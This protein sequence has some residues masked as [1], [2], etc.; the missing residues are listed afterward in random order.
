MWRALQRRGSLFL[1]ALSE[2]V[3]A[4]AGR[5]RPYGVLSIGLRGDLAEEGGE[6]RI[7]GFVRR[8]TTDYLSLISLLRWA[9]EDAR[10]AAVF[11]S[12]DDVRASW[13]R[14]QGLRR[15]VQRLREA[16]KHVWVHLNTAGVHEYYLASAA[17][18]ISL[19]PTA[20]LNVTGLSS[21]AVFFLDALRK[22][23]VEAEVIQMGRYKAAG[24]SFT[25]RDMSPAHRE[26][27]ESLIDDLYS[28]LVDGIGAGRGLEPGAVRE[29][30]DRGPFVAREALEAGLIDRLAYE[31]EVESHLVEACSSAPLIDRPAYAKRRGRE[32]RREVLRRGRGT[33]G[34]L[35][36]CGTIKMGESIPGP[37]GTAAVGSASV[38]AALKQLRER[39]DVRALVVRVASPGGSV[40][41]SDLM[42]REIVRTREKKPVV[43]SFGDV[44]ASGGYYVALGG[45]PVLAEP[46]SITGSI[47]V[48]AGKA[49]L[50]GLYDRIG[51]TKELVSRGRHAA[52]YSD[53]APL[54]SEERARIRAEAEAFYEGFIG[55]VAE[56][57]RLSPGAVAAA[58]E[59]RVWSGRQAWT[60]GLVDEMGGLEEALDAAKKSIGVPVDEPIALERF[61]K[62]RRLWRL[63][64][65]LNL[66]AP[67]HL[68]ESLT[69]LSPLR[70]IWRERVWAVLPF[71][72]RFF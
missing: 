71:Q 63:S 7:L 35:H 39:G 54:G 27:M 59:G 40:V 48:I 49:S 13:A 11:I 52:L 47:G 10:L 4:V 44:A 29:L 53:Y 34:I 64:V 9:R 12:C 56:A 17:E 42:W 55:K 33:L 65:D 15:A 18:H 68:T 67:W 41:A 19:A 30:L 46:G 58:G 37:E 3:L 26:M 32:I 6:R 25:R 62:P 43:V 72:L 69:T 60:R 22:V 57:R 24:E 36:I 38:A 50:R 51:V 20:T 70:Y 66:P 45:S 23:G 14:L 28:Q 1:L 21:E 5:R 2:F 16:G 31:D 61:P 8:S